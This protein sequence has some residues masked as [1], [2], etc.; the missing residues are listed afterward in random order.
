MHPTD[1]PV[2]LPVSYHETKASKLRSR[3]TQQRREA[4]QYDTRT[5]KD[6]RDKAAARAELQKRAKAHVAREQQAARSRIL[7]DMQAAA[8]S[9]AGD[10]PGIHTATEMPT[11]AVGVASGDEDSPRIKSAR[12]TQGDPE[13]DRLTEVH[14]RSR[15]SKIES[16]ISHMTREMLASAGLDVLR[17]VEGTASAKQI[18]DGI[19]ESVPRNRADVR[20][21]C[22]WLYKHTHAVRSMTAADKILELIICVQIRQQLSHH[23]DRDLKML[24]REIGQEW[25]PAAQEARSNAIDRLAQHVQ[26]FML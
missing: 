23:D 20:F 11:G 3:Y 19:K 25:D 17:F 1:P 22:L 18:F 13:L 6:E 9:D 15:H 8:D 14:R 16:D 21:Y 2:Y 24:L 5:L 12:S 4:G 26:N 7:Q 10:K